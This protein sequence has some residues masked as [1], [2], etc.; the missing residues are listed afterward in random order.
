MPCVLHRTVSTVMVIGSLVNATEIALSGYP[1]EGRVFESRLD[2]CL[3]V[4]RLCVKHTMFK[5]AF[6]T[7]N[8]RFFG[9]RLGGY[10]DS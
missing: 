1:T 5:A 6:Q 7:Y 8:G 2:L 4:L 10:P 3:T 9:G